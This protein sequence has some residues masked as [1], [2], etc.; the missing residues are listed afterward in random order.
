MEFSPKSKHKK[1]K[2]YQQNNKKQDSNNIPIQKVS[3]PK[4]NQTQEKVKQNCP[5]NKKGW[6]IFADKKCIPYS[7]KCKYNKE[8]F[9]NNTFY[10]TTENNNKTNTTT[11]RSNYSLY[12]DERHGSNKVITTLSDNSIVELYVFKGFL[13]LNPSQ[14]IDYEMTIKDLHTN[15]TNTILVAYNKTTGRYYISE[16]Q[17][18]YWHK[19]NFFPKIVLN[20][21]NDGSIPMLTDGL[22]EFSKLALYGYKAGIH[23]LSENQRHRILEY[24]IDNKIM[25]GYEIIKHLQGLIFMRNQQ[26]NKDFSVSIEDWEND[27]VFVEKFITEKQRRNN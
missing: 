9:K 16:T 18:K 5:C 8:V 13:Q 2:R 3:M 19:R 15:R 10:Y 23:G 12:E 7:L 26:Y 27:I 22:Q 21:C 1:K 20:M 4:V 14:T 6:C 11:Q 24:V 17:I 25:K